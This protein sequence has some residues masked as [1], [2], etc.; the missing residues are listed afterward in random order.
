[1][2]LRVF[3]VAFEAISSGLAKEKPPALVFFANLPAESLL[4][5]CLCLS[6]PRRVLLRVQ[7][8]RFAGLGARKSF[9]TALT[10]A[11]QCSTST[12]LSSVIF[13]AG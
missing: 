10:Q 3:C 11:C 8:L 2:P 6:P 13:S 7:Y 5:A 4:S 1:V 9:T 12:I